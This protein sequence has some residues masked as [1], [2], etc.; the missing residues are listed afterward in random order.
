MKISLRNLVDLDS[1]TSKLCESINHDSVIM[2]RGELGV[3]KTTLSASILRRLVSDLEEFTS[4]TFNILH[5]YY[6]KLR[7]CNINHLD[8]YR[9]EHCEELYEIGFSNILEDGIVLIEWPEI[10]LP[11]LRNIASE[12]LM[13][14]D[15][16]FH[17][18][19]LR[20]VSVTTPC[21]LN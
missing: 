14:I 2:L 3:G 15:L 4:P 5:Q 18:E 16:S 1:F 6:S 9:I 10:A 13:M 12:R 21:N 8:L 19:D 20:Y 17:G 7:Q 11:I